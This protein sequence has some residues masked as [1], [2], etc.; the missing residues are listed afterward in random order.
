MK[1]SDGYLAGKFLIAGPNM[2]DKR[3]KRTVIYMCAHDENHAMGIIINRP[4]KDLS[5]STMLPHLD[6][7]DP[8]TYQDSPV[9]YGGP[10]DSERGFVL[11]SLDFIDP[12]NSL[13][14]G[15]NLGLTT[16]KSILHALTRPNAPKKAV[17][18]L[19]YAGWTAG[20]LEAEILHNSWFISPADDKIIF[21]PNAKE[22]WEQALA[23]S[24][25]NPLFLASQSG[26]A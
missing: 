3:F 21:A 15:K 13:K 10:V 19:G 11:H 8:I 4:K 26:H 5:L 20:Q 24:G 23:K 17:M 6:V 12:A 14:L 18:A 7:K 16:S 1:G 2:A 9:L 22:K 25:V